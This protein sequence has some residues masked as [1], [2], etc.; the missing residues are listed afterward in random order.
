MV[1]LYSLFVFVRAEMWDE[2]AIARGI[3]STGVSY[4]GTAAYAAAMEAVQ[5][6]LD[7]NV[8]A[9]LSAQL[10]TRGASMTHDEA[11]SWLRDTLDRVA[12]TSESGGS[13]TVE[14]HVRNIRERLDATNR[15]QIVAW[16]MANE[17]S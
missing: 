2:T 16:V 1:G 8:D 15:T 7:S 17:P 13:Y 6:A 10:I 5:Q 9:E 14:T 11:L 12:Q 4:M 3:A